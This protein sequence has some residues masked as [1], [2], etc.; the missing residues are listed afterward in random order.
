MLASPRQQDQPGAM[1]VL[2]PCGGCRYDR[3]MLADISDGM[4]RP[5][6]S[7][8]RYAPNENALEGARKETGCEEK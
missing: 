3:G 4:R 1:R 7:G 2:H 8:M 5:V 6:S